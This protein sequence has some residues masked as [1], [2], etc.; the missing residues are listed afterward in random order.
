MENDQIDVQGELATRTSRV[1]ASLIDLVILM[2]LFFPILFITGW[3]EKNMAGE[4]ISIWQ[5]LLL[6][7][8]SIGIFLIV[9]YKLLK[10]NGQT[11]GKK[12]LKIRIV[13]NEG[14]HAEVMNH[15]L[16]RYAVYFLPNQ[17]PYFGTLFQLINICFIFREDKRC[18]HDIIA[19]TKVIRS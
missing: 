14:G 6:S 18:L 1:A 8:I 5:T 19:G 9:N 17:I 2:A 12:I 3:L 10:N 13:A 4:E 16:K 7:A 11:I 15:L